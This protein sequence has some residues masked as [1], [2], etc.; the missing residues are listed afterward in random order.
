MK[1]S[2]IVSTLALA[3]SVEG[4]VSQ[5]GP[6]L[7]KNTSKLFSQEIGTDGNLHG[8]SSCFMPLEQVDEEY[9]APRI[10]QIAG[11]YPGVTKEEILSVT[12]EQ[13]AEK[14]Q[15]AYD[16]SDPDGPQMGTVALPGCEI[17]D[18]CEDPA[19]I[20]AEHFALGVPLPEVLTDPVDLLVVVDRAK[21]TFAERKFLVMD[22]PGKGIVIK[23]YS[24]K[25]EMPE[26]GEVIGRVDFVQVPWLPCMKK[27]KSGFQEDDSL[28]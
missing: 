14:G 1:G 4:W 10:I 22:V 24:T 15:W 20:I 5:N 27:K 17:I 21:K 19:V 18:L 16:F 23:A 26:G 9:F 11:M 28:Y 3:T 13:P 2:L 8:E 6:A 7:R 12:S 25:A